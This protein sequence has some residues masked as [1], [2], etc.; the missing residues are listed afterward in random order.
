MSRMELYERRFTDAEALDQI[1]AIIGLSTTDPS[2][3]P[4]D[5]VWNDIVYYVQETGRET[6]VPEGA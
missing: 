2:N 1:A 4:L 5:E 6:D 3:N